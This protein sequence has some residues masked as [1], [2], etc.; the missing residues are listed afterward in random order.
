MLLLVLMLM[1]IGTY[2]VYSASYVGVDSNPPWYYVMKHLV[3]MIIGVAAGAAMFALAKTSAPLR[4]FII[5]LF[6]VASV[7]L[8][9]VAYTFGEAIGGSKR[10]I[11][12]LGINIQPSE[13]IKVG[14][15]LLI[16][17]LLVKKKPNTGLIPYI[18][19]SGI[20]ASIVVIENLS[21]GILIFLPIVAIF[22]A[23]GMR[24]RDG[25]F[26]LGTLVVGFVAALIQAPYR[27]R[28]LTEYA[29]ILL[30][31]MAANYQAKQSFYALADGGILGV[32]FTN[33]KQKFFHLPEHHTDFIFAIVGEEL[34]FIL[35]LVLLIL[36]FLLGYMIVQIALET[37]DL[38]FKRAIFG[39]GILILAQTALNLGVV[40]GLFPVTGV[41]L[42]FISYGGS[43]MLSFLMI[44][45][46]ILGAT[47]P[48]RRRKNEGN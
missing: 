6:N 26:I 16:A 17:S 18:A 20:M 24:W 28:R 12:L 38:F 34:G 44:I 1:A 5:I 42:P 14:L 21:S 40:T 46:F 7:A 9:M 37:E 11:T 30:N 32:G 29:G 41:T 43:S 8:L 45:G 27:L 10:W 4:N 35:A 23:L 19:L 13:L 31:P 22:I 47:L 2:M 39:F 48:K 15:I 3:N 25:L 33:S 36:L